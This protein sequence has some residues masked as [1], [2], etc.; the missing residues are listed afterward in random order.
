AQSARSAAR[1][2]GHPT[3][4]GH[5]FDERSSAEAEPGAHREEDPAQPQ[6][7]TRS[8]SNPPE[9]LS[10]T[11]NTKTSPSTSRRAVK[12]DATHG[13][14]GRVI[15]LQNS[16]ASLTPRRVAVSRPRQRLPRHELPV[17]TPDSSSTSTAISVLLFTTR[18]PPLCEHMFDASSVPA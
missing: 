15:Q 5:S 17:R 18:H 4:A 9:P 3:Q 14:G 8:S 7:K 11:S 1:P 13:S 6:A 2:T 12:R 16:P 10:L